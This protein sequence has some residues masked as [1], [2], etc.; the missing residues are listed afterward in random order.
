MISEVVDPGG[1]AAKLS[2]DLIVVVLLIVV[3]LGEADG[4]AAGGADFT[5]ESHAKS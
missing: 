1:G 3:G 5:R 4:R 2:G